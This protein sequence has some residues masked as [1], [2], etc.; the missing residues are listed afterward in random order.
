MSL[1]VFKGTDDFNGFSYFHVRLC[2]EEY[3]QSSA[4]Q[5]IFVWLQK[6]FPAL[7]LLTFMIIHLACC[8]LVLRW[9]WCYPFCA[10]QACMGDIQVVVIEIV[11]PEIISTA[12]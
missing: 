1:L 2:V 9:Y 7:K 3:A 5:R 12:A 4:S 10:L 6:V 11:V 8:I